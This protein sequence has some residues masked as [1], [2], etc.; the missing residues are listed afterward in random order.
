[1]ITCAIDADTPVSVSNI[2]TAFGPSGNYSRG[3]AVRICSGVSMQK[4]HDQ[5]WVSWNGE[6]SA[7]SIS[8]DTSDYLGITSANLSSQ[9]PPLP[10]IT[11]P[12]DYGSFYPIS[13]QGNLT[14][15]Y[16]QVASVTPD[17]VKGMW[18]FIG[19][20]ADGWGSRAFNIGYVETGTT[21]SSGQSMNYE[22]GGDGTDYSDVCYRATA[23]LYTGTPTS[24]TEIP[25]ISFRRINDNGYVGMWCPNYATSNQ[26]WEIRI[27]DATNGQVGTT[28]T[29]DFPVEHANKPTRCQTLRE[30]AVWTQIYSGSNTS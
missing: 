10:T 7:A 15:D 13:T 29:F 30:D 20:Y 2:V 23:R 12:F 6:Q 17:G 24:S 9:K 18:G 19:S 22:S 4:Y 14:F 28:T 3:S 8:G 11:S 16:E 21:Y 5:R 1:V 26:R 27:L 25:S